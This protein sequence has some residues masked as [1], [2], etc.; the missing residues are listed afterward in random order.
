ME[1]YGQ[2]I[3]D[4]E[5]TRDKW[6]EENRGE[7]RG[8][9]GKRRRHRENEKNEAVEEAGEKKT[10]GKQKG[11]IP[12][13]TIKRL[14]TY[15]CP[16]LVV[17]FLWSD[18]SQFRISK[19]FI[20]YGMGAIFGIGVIE[21]SAEDY[22]YHTGIQI[23]FAVFYFIMVDKL[24]LYE[25]H[26][27]YILY[28]MSCLMGLGWSLSVHYR[29]AI[30]L[31]VPHLLG[32]RGRGILL[33]LLM[34]IVTEGPVFNIQRNIE[35]V[36]ESVGCTIELQ[37]N[38][39][40]TLWKLML[41]PLR[42]IIRNM[43]ENGKEFGEET[44]KVK[45]SFV[46]VNEE[47]LMKQGYDISREKSKAHSKMST[48]ILYE[49][50]TKLRCEY[51]VN[52]GIDRCKA[53]FAQKHKACLTK[54][55]VPLFNHLFCLPMTFSFLCNIM[56]VMT[57]WCK[58]RIPV[59]KN[60]GQLYDKVNGSVDN[61]NKEFT[62]EM[63]ISK[64]EQESIIGANIT[65]ADVTESVREEI[66]KK[67]TL[68]DKV[69]LVF[70]LLASLSFLLLFITSFLY[71]LN[72]NRDIRYDNIY[73]STYFRQ[74]DARRRRVDRRHILPLKKAERPDVIFP[75]QRKVHSTEMKTLILELV[76]YVAI[77][78]V[79]IALFILDWLLFTMLDI[80]RRHSFLEYSF[81]ESHQLKI[82]V[83]GSSILANLIR[84][85]VSAFNTSLDVKIESNNLHCLP[86]PHKMS[87]QSTMLTLVPVVGMI[88]FC[89]LQTYS[90]R[91]RRVIAGFCF[92]KREKKR[93]LFLYNEY[94]RK[95]ISFAETQR[96]KILLLARKKQLWQLH[97]VAG[98]LH[99]LVPCLQRF[100]R[101]RCVVCS[102]GPTQTS[103][104]CPN[105]G[106]AAMYCHLCWK[107]VKRF[108]FY[109]MPFEDF[110]SEASDEE[111]N[112]VYGE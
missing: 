107:D 10:N 47:I 48:Q 90:Y 33:M 93:V 7:S 76:Q 39:T 56:K 68:L 95:R 28:G 108:C 19:F 105:E 94:L 42:Q 29:C 11:K 30:M 66:L 40:K 96:K 1:E 82:E 21:L 75:W 6:D 55:V 2:E 18:P 5:P 8:Y 46:K 22:Q 23:C 77:I 41:N 71:T 50:R 87:R 36:G 67:K 111:N 65:K 52:L 45:S 17:D 20:G 24:D 32:S 38:H 51:I 106:C 89:F 86:V 44:K 35:V 88:V 98:T 97:G 104:Y 59:D 58:D 57:P 49:M 91:L 26:K 101:K 62:A 4:R 74:I 99:R 83:G 14:F 43:K 80:I 112:P 110:V 69:I 103:Y 73:V 109:C 54:L 78:L 100:I 63:A 25:D 70:K 27:L 92:P 34:A 72:Y 53:W 84:R 81:I 31:M 16:S 15:C 3:E 85:A 9:R 60:F 13:S 102:E 61:L 37:I 79:V 12:H 64:M